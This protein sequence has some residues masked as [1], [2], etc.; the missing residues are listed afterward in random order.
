MHDI[1]PDD[2]NADITGRKR[3][4]NEGEVADHLGESN[5]T[6]IKVGKAIEK[7]LTL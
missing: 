3:S 5:E 4:S 1:V 7:D 6:V 2:K